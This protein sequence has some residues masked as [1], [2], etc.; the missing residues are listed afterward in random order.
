MPM[1]G[2]GSNVTSLSKPSTCH[3][4]DEDS[5]DD[6]G[7]AFEP[8][9]APEHF[10]QAP[11]PHAP[12]VTLWAHMHS[13]GW[14]YFAGND[15]NTWY[16]VHPSA[17]K[18]KKADML[19]RCMEGMQ[20]FATKEDIQNYARKHLG[21]T[22]GGSAAA[23]RSAAGDD[24]NKAQK[25]DIGSKP[26]TKRGPGRPS[27]VKTSS[28]VLVGT[29]S[30]ATTDGRCRHVLRG[31]W[32]REHPTESAPQRFELCR[33]IPPEGDLLP[34]TAAGIFGGYFV[35]RQ[36]SKGA[37][38]SSV[39]VTEGNVHLSFTEL[40]DELRVHGAGHDEYG[41]FDLVGSGNKVPTRDSY[42]VRLRKKYEEDT[43][44]TA[45]R[46][47]LEDHDESSAGS[48]KK[49]K[50]S[51]SAS[52]D[53]EYGGD[54]EAG[55]LRPSVDDRRSC[56]V[57]ARVP[58]TV[59]VADEPDGNA[60]DLVE[61]EEV[62]GAEEAEEAAEK[63]PAASAKVSGTV[64]SDVA[65]AASKRRRRRG[66]DECDPTAK[67]LWPPLYSMEESVTAGPWQE[68]GAFCH[69]DPPM[70][71][72]PLSW[73][74]KNVRPKYSQMNLDFF[75]SAGIVNVQDL[76]EAD[77]AN[78]CARLMDFAHFKA[79]CAFAQWKNRLKQRRFK[80]S[81][82]TK[83]FYDL[84]HPE[85]AKL[86]ITSWRLAAER[87]YKKMAP[88]AHAE[89][90][91]QTQ[92]TSDRAVMEREGAAAPRG[93]RDAA[94]RVDGAKGTDLLDQILSVREA[95]TIRK[96]FQIDSARQ[97]LA[98]DGKDAIRRLASL[99]GVHEDKDIACIAEGVWH[100]WTRRTEAALLED[101]SG[102]DATSSASPSTMTPARPERIPFKT[103]L[104]YFDLQFL[105]SQGISSDEEL[106][107]AD[108]VQ[109]AYKY[110]K[111]LKK[112]S[113]LPSHQRQISLDGAL[114]VAKTWRDEACRACGD[115][116]GEETCAALRRCSRLGRD[117]WQ[118]QELMNT[119]LNLCRTVADPDNPSLPQRTIFAYD[120]TSYVLYEFFVSVR[121]SG[122][123]PEAGYGAFLTYKG[124]KVLRHS[125]L[126][127]RKNP[128]DTPSMSQTRKP[129]DAAFSASGAVVTLR[130][131]VIHTDERHYGPDDPDRIGMFR[132]FALDDFED[133]ADNVTFSSKHLGCAL[134]EL[135][136]RYAPLLP[137]DRK[138]DQLFSV[139]D[140]IFSHEPSSWRFDV[141][142][143]L[144]G[145][146]QVVDFTDDA[147]GAPH[148]LARANM[149][150]YVNEVGH[151]MDLVENVVARMLSPR[152]VAY[153]F[154]IDKPMAMGESVELLVNYKEHYEQ[155]RERRGYGKANLRHNV[156]SD[157]H[158][159]TRVLRNLKDRFL[160]ENMILQ[161]TEDE[162]GQVVEFIRTKVFDGV[163]EATAAFARGGGED[164]PDLLRQF[165]A[166]RRM[167]WLSKILR[168]RF[169]E[170]LG[171]SGAASTPLLDGE[172]R[173][174]CT[175]EKG[176]FVFV[177]G[178][179][180]NNPRPAYT[181]LATIMSI[182]EDKF[183][184]KEF[185]VFMS[186]GKSIESVPE[187]VVTVPT[188]DDFKDAPKR[189]YTNW[190]KWKKQQDLP[191]MRLK[192]LK[193][194]DAVKW[195]PSFL[196]TLA[197]GMVGPSEM[198]TKLFPSLRW[199][200]SEE[201]LFLLEKHKR[202]LHPFDEKAWCPLSVSLLTKCL[203]LI[204]DYLL[205]GRDSCILFATLLELAR[206][207]A[208]TV[209]N[210]ARESRNNATTQDVAQVASL[211]FVETSNAPECLRVLI[212][213]SI[214]D[215]TSDVKDYICNPQPLDLDW[216]LTHQVVLAVHSVA[217]LIDC[218]LKTGAGHPLYSIEKLCEHIG[219]ED[220]SYLHFYTS[221]VQEWRPLVCKETGSM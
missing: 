132:E 165:I 214:N 183:H 38:Q 203:H 218:S 76:F 33:E 145:Y 21:W 7:D 119:A 169:H 179:P 104:S 209:R 109:H 103:R 146:P 219:L 185:E 163:K 5:R 170:L 199:E 118:Q 204:A 51:A 205:M 130:G 178:W 166:R 207:A 24:A 160:V 148:A 128:R 198:Q 92:G 210:I 116:S 121:A 140:F 221:T 50:C 142:E 53:S 58:D 202:L 49:R 134:I 161:F 64:F 34:L 107:E 133:A 4:S 95:A 94:P 99:F 47:E 213:E 172:I 141:N 113:C 176:M 60:K 149:S 111:Y 83:T 8:D 217:S 106:A 129:L 211:A 16:W 71:C 138:T 67:L 18:M 196:W 154:H 45:P 86:S 84:Y 90:R 12:W 6:V 97:L 125:S 136:D 98:L 102:T 3:A 162:I 89:S 88:V 35:H 26:P 153:Y 32:E 74:V 201:L 108:P 43:H 36:T 22:G 75:A 200:L 61:T 212:V 14:G 30:H 115:V 59:G 208:E 1:T 87:W 177:H 85:C 96:Y 46:S 100:S 57:D 65:Y 48:H 123:S 126:G 82:E 27:K 139:K 25:N 143:E 15:P 39:I 151:N 55:E 93:R 135:E 155:M 110:V 2:D 54:A 182:S 137:A 173:E 131:R 31:L 164:N 194:F 11:D 79:A 69:L 62:A 144:Y 77:A 156:Q 187:A 174:E 78:L 192:T 81:G 52:S 158:D 23:P 180:K 101:K 29:L 186:D 193:G 191:R 70:F 127:K 188:D 40:D 112:M 13:R 105:R 181:G 56:T 41:P 152:A 215:N 175:F 63:L 37:A 28:C 117:S 73:N 20:Y 42:H 150:M 216:Y 80:I 197:A 9:A 114:E 66:R 206:Q 168:T 17:A 171:Q 19:R 72:R 122:C 167:H 68:C 10:P 120:R 44:S 190:L 184:R 189:T 220:T 159:V 91:T 147:T 195:D 157:A 124:A